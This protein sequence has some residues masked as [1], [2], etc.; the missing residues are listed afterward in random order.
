MCGVRVCTFFCVYPVS[1]CA[2]TCVSQ[3]TLGQKTAS[4][5]CPHFAPW[6]GQGLLFTTESSR[7]AGLWAPEIL[8]LTPQPCSRNPGA[9]DACCDIHCTSH[10]CAASTF[11]PSYHPGRLSHCYL[12]IWLILSSFRWAINYCGGFENPRSICLLCSR[13]SQPRHMGRR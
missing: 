6:F 10:N 9:A 11:S 7:P 4:G 3:H 13:W 8:S 1:A 2:D 12:C 5:V